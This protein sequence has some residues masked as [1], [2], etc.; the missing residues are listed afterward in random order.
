MGPSSSVTVWRW[1]RPSLTLEYGPSLG[2]S[3]VSVPVHPPLEASG[4]A[5]ES[6]A[7]PV[8]EVSVNEESY[9]YEDEVRTA[10]WVGNPVDTPVGVTSENEL[11]KLAS[12]RSV[13]LAPQVETSSENVASGLDVDQVMVFHD[14]AAPRVTRSHAKFNACP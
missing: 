8:L 13:R 11:G 6:L 2:W 5:S 7:E 1:T 3:G 4:L 14:T 10:E 12:L 9:H